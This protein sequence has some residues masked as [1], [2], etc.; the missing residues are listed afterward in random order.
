[1]EIKVNEQKDK[2]KQAIRLKGQSKMERQKN[3]IRYLNMTSL[4][5][6]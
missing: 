5:L 2:R 4:L 3:I 6:E 1:M